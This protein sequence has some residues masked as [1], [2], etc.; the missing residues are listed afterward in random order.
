MSR[1]NFNMKIKKQIR[2]IVPNLEDRQPFT[3]AE[4]KSMLYDE[5]V[6]N[7]PT[8]QIGGFFKTYEGR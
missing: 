6:T 4:L 7:T 2:K 1:S 3:S 8:I 5:G